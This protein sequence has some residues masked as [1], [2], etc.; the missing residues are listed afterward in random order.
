MNL[1]HRAD[2][3]LAKISRG[4]AVKEYTVSKSGKAKEKEN[5]LDVSKGRSKVYTKIKSVKKDIEKMTFILATHTQ[6]D[7]NAGDG[8]FKLDDGMGISTAHIP[9]VINKLTELSK[10]LKEQQEYEDKYKTLTNL[11]ETRILTPCQCSVCLEEIK[12]NTMAVIMRC[13]HTHHFHCLNTWIITG[14]PT[15]PTCRQ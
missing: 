5:K 15:C 2:K 1:G 11:R 4:E 10:T 7:R 9:S 14:N 12:S 8:W 13:G 6:P 3:Y